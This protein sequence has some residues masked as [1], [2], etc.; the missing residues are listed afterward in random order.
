MKKVILLCLLYL[1][2]LVKPAFAAD[3]T[4]SAAQDL[5][6]RVATKVA[7]LSEKLQK[8]YWG[9][10]KNLGTSS[11][12][13]VTTGGEKA[14]NTNDATSFYRIRANNR[15]EINF[16]GLKIGDDIAAVGTIDPIT[17]DL[18]A[19]QIIAKIKREN[20]VG[21]ITAVD[22][23][24]VTVGTIK[25]DLADAILKMA[26]SSGKITSA[27]LSDFK[28]GNAIFAIAHSP[29]A[30]TGVFSVLKALTISQ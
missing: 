25:I 23:T 1:T 7:E 12:V 9:K 3:A 8:S 29:D 14:V 17:S 4:K 16:A 30:K 22:K 10:I 13:L 20:V 28:E 11:V 15:T 26:S 6:D 5:L 24:I 21:Q 27:K 18:T 19:A 2:L